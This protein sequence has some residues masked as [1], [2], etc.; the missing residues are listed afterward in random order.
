[1]KKHSRFWSLLLVICMVASMLV[2]AVHAE[3]A[4]IPVPAEIAVEDVVS[5]VNCLLIATD[6]INGQDYIY[7]FFNGNKMMVYN[8]DTGKLVDREVN[9]FSTPRHVFIGDDHMVWVS[10]A[11]KFLYKYDPFTMTS[12]KYE[13]ADEM[14]PEAG[15]FN[16]AGLVG[17]GSGNLYFGTYNTAYFG[18]FNIATETFTQLTGTLN[19]DPSM[20]QDAQRSG[21]GG[22]IIKDGYAYV[23][24]NGNKNNDSVATNEIL[25]IDLATNEIVDFVNLSSRM[26]ANSY[27]DY[28]SLVGDVIMASCGKVTTGSLAVDINTMELIDIPGLEQGYTGT[29]SEEI[30][31]KV[32]MMG[33][34]NVGLLAYDIATRT[35]ESVGIADSGMLKWTDC[36]VTV[37]GNDKLP[38]KSLVTMVSGSIN[39][40]DIVLYNLETKETVAL[41]DYTDGLGSGNILRALDITPDGKTIYASSYGNNQLAVIDVASK[42]VVALHPTYNTQIEG[43]IQYDGTLYIGNYSSCIAATIDPVTGEYR[44]LVTLGPS[45]FYQYRLHATAAGDDKVFFG[46][47][48]GS[49]ALGGTLM[50]HDIEQDRIYVAA[51]PTIEDVFYT[52]AGLVGKE[53]WHCA[54]TDKRAEFKDV[55]GDGAINREDRY[56][57][58]DGV[59]VQLFTGV[60]ENQVIVSMFYQDG[61][62]YGCT[63]RNGGSGSVAKAKNSCLF[64]YDVAAMELVKTYDLCDAIPGLATPVDI[65]DVVAADPDVPGKFWG[66]V[67]DTL[68]SWSFDVDSKTLSVKKALSL[69]TSSYNYIGNALQGTDIIM[70]DD[71]MYVNFGSNGIYMIDRY[72]VQTYYKLSSTVAKKMVKAYDGNIYFHDNCTD[73]KVLK[74]ADFTTSITDAKGIEKAKTMIAALDDPADVTLDDE[75]QILKTREYYERISDAGKSK[76]DITRLLAAE[77]ALAPLRAAADQAAADVVIGKINA[78]GTVTLDSEAAILEARAA[79]EALT[80]DQKD[81]VTNL[82]VLADAEDELIYLK[83]PAADKEAAAAVSAMIDA[84]GTV[85]VDSEK[86]V[87]DARK[88]YDALSDLQKSLVKNLATLEEAEVKLNKLLTAAREVYDFD[89]INSGMGYKGNSLF[90]YEKL[91]I[92]IEEKY[93]SGVWNYNVLD[94]NFTNEKANDVTFNGGGYLQARAVPGDWLAFTIRTPGAGEWSLTANHPACFAGAEEVKVYILP[95]STTDIP[96]AMTEDHYVGSYNCYNP[97]VQ[98]EKPS[99]D[100]NVDS[101]LGKWTAG[102]DQEYILVLECVKAN[103]DSLDRVQNSTTALDYGSNIYLTRLT[104]WEADPTSDNVQAKIDALGEITLESEDA[105][106]AARAAFEALSPTQQAR[107]DIAK[108]VA[109]EKKLQELKDAFEELY[110]FDVYSQGLKMGSNSMYLQKCLDSLTEHYNAGKLNWNFAGISIANKATDNDATFMAAGYGYIRLRSVANGDWV[111]FSM[112]SPGAGSWSLVMNHPA[113][114]FGAKKVNAYLLPGDTRDIG[115]A[116]KNAEPV[117][118]YNCSDTAFTAHTP[119]N[120]DSNRDTVFG[121]VWTAEAGEKYILVL[122]VAEVNPDSNGDYMYFTSLYMKQADEAV[123]A[124]QEKIN[125]IGIVTLLSENAIKEARAAYEA[126]SDELKPYIDEGKIAAAEA[127]LAELKK[128]VEKKYNF[129]MYGQGLKMAGNAIFL[130]KTLD[131]LTGHYNSGA[132][133]W[134]FKQINHSGSNN[135]DATFMSATQGYFRVRSSAVGDWIAFAVNNPGEGN[136]NLTFSH[137]ATKYGSPKLSVF[138]LPGDTADIAGAL[139]SATPIG[140]IDCYNSAVSGHTPADTSGNRSTT[141]ENVWTTGTEETYIM[142]LRVDQLP[143]KLATAYYYLS[144]IVAQNVDADSIMVQK[145]IDSIGTVTVES[146]AMIAAAR[147][148]YESLDAAQKALVDP[149]KLIAA[150][151]ELIRVKKEAADKAAA[152][153]VN[154]KIEA[155]GEVTLD[156]EAAIA[157]ARAAYNALTDDQKAL[158]DETKIAA[159]E[160]TL[161]ALKKAEADKAAADKVNAMIDAIGEVT[162]ES[163]DALKAAS[164]AY[165]ALTDDQKTLVKADVLKAAILRYGELVAAERQ[166]KLD[167]EAAAAAQAK[168]EAIGEVTL[169]SE[170]AIQAAR[171]A[172]DA[173]TETQKALV[174]TTKLIAAEEAYQKLLEPTNPDTGDSMHMMVYVLTAVLSITALATVMIPVFKR[175]TV[176]R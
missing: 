55:N 153:A 130:Q 117:G 43:M 148:A 49:N 42:K 108:L 95:A 50:W 172:Y 5:S 171:Q 157:E 105:I 2:P 72:D 81:R 46:T 15:S 164:D 141:L 132:I 86:V 51:G 125:A 34:N 57:Q 11:S 88:A 167:K 114:K 146:E 120:P 40:V 106:E 7:L 28:V 19:T 121:G 156:D 59:D 143:G 12:T 155:I 128:D 27:M 21:W 159:A 126:L 82:A 136:W 13:M 134:N 90:S 97:D 78:I 8:L 173:L 174:D 62:I 158:V 116:L 109:A 63:T 113:T 4:S 20:P 22:V 149:A 118:C 140:A 124:V 47:C 29:V 85:T 102:A 112:D 107:V 70:D 101:V 69:G 169:D 165:G 144:N 115:A 68:F 35:V 123:L 36:L 37:E 79:F 92:Y 135:N 25:K 18:K 64:V 74:V 41:T 166:E 163:K 33:A 73:L 38:G 44:R 3:P 71:F 30:D 84:I 162:L 66:V 110:N 93:N 31:G 176:N 83:I 9:C 94:I 67:S 65:V 154:A 75:A 1:M 45:I 61:Y 137:P 48:P 24:N 119:T 138:M 87:T 6:V 58:V 175:K 139:T 53:T 80:D 16:G 111:A 160:K 145:L 133:N 150:E 151:A 96:A 10:G 122:E 14:F 104:M 76:V 89:Y 142:V 103:Q 60:V 170:D 127:A 129:D 32:Y 147:E 77:A 54:A 99:I 161:E 56:A 26:G 39:R 98:N 100:Y 52:P 152:D 17:D 23:P 168:I 131:S 91:L